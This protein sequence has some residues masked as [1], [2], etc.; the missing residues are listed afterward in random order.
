[1]VIEKWAAQN[2]WVIDTG[3]SKSLEKCTEETACPQNSAPSKE[4]HWGT[5][6]PKKLCIPEPEQTAKP[7]PSMTALQSASPCVLLI[8]SSNANNPCPAPFD[9]TM[10]LPPQYWGAFNTAQ[11]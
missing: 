3:S 7:S 11:K 8:Y 10:A 6:K 4:D 1:M 2:G 9:L 5:A